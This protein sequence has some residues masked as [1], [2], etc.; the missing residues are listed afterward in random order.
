MIIVSFLKEKISS[1][2][3]SYNSKNT[4]GI[5][6]IDPKVDDYEMLMAGVTPGLEVVLLDDNQGGDWE[7]EVKIGNVAAPL[8]FGAETMEAYN[9]V[10]TTTRVSVA[11]DGTQG[12]SYSEINTL[13][14]VQT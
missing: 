11:S 13:L 12:N 4:T 2:N 7:M 9:A 1:K 14:A 10:F 8:A 6:F 5:V 3:S